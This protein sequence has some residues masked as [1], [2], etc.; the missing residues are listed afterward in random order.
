MT[1]RRPG[2][3]AAA[4]PRLPGRRRPH[5]RVLGTEITLIE[6]LRRRAEEELDI[7]LSFEVLDF[8]AAQRKAALEPDSFDIYDQCFHNLDI[9][10]F[11]RAIQPI[12]LSRIDRW[13]EVSDL[14]K[15]GRISPLAS[16]GRGENPVRTLYV[17]PDLS[18]G[19]T[20]SARIS[21][22]PTVHNLDAFAYRPALFPE[23]RS[24][25]A[26]WSWLFDPEA[27]GRLVLVDEPGIGVF[28]AALAFEARDEIRFGDIGNMTV[29]E[30]DALMAL[31]WARKKEGVFAGLWRT[32]AQS[33]AG[34]VSGRA[35]IGSMWSPGITAVRQ[36][37]HAL[38][39][40]VPREGYRA[41]HSGL[42][43]SA[44]LS[45]ELL[46][47]AYRYL[48]WWL[49]GLPGALLARQGFY[50]S[51]PGRVRAAMPPA[52]WDYWYAGKPA[53]SDL[54]GPDGRPMVR[55]GGTRAGGPYW[56]RAE[57][58]TVWN[59]AM[60]E[61]NYLARRWSQFASSFS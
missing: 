14:T 56:Q 26:S 61:Y 44:R 50:M 37:G 29:G 55:A 6:P 10:W 59:T 23:R 45:G 60:D 21:M 43:L 17:Q 49:D 47:A 48:N 2:A 20:A 25:E 1:P 13:A 58:I 39:E 30:I 41:W 9:V 12:E 52:E 36:A 33:A 34:M 4:P 19:E 32:A 16:F 8:I 53:A 31:L 22:L 15:R 54:P 7:T 51:V 42:S 35:G 28:D 18:L 38:E 11:W 57:H 24:D 5:L 40:A 3:T 46:D 27:K